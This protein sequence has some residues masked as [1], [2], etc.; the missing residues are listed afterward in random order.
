MTGQMWM[1]MGMVLIVVSLTG[2][3]GI[4]LWIQKLKKEMRE[5]E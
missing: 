3:I 1:T 4:Q 2:G 5:R